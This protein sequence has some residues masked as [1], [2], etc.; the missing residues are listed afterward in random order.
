[1]QRLGVLSKYEQTE[2]Q[3]KLD[4]QQ[5][6]EMNQGIARPVQSVR[7]QR[8]TKKDHDLVGFLKVKALKQHDLELQLKKQ[9][10]LALMFISH[11]GATKST[12]WPQRTRTSSPKRRA[13]RT[14][15]TAIIDYIYMRINGVSFLSTSEYILSRFVYL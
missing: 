8:Y 1:L 4:F 2:K 10:Q 3:I 11:L 5:L 15:K 9:R 14:L 6:V 12:A 7:F 13:R